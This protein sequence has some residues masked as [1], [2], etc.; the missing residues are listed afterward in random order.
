MF[1]QL[2]DGVSYCHN[3]GVFHRDLKASKHIS[4]HNICLCYLNARF[5]SAH[6]SN[7]KADSTCSQRMF[8]LMQK[9]TSRYLILDSVLCPSILGYAS[10]DIKH[11]YMFISSFVLSKLFVMPQDDGLL[12]TTCGSPNYVA[13]EILS[14]RGYDGATS[15][16]WSCG[17]I[18]YVILTGY[19]P[20]DDRNLAV[21]Y[22]KVLMFCC[23]SCF[24]FFLLLKCP[25]VFHFLEKNANV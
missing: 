4:Y 7:T 3:K 13:P 22:Q 21:L 6:H 11:V 8:L 5:F 1:Q 17:V 10:V 9:E 25:I 18:L 20:F 14:N 12:H 23:R 2:I 24:F 16:I 19:L 15:D